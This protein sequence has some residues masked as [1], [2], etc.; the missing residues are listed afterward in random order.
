MS[1]AFIVFPTALLLFAVIT[2]A[3]TLGSGPTVIDGSVEAWFRRHA[4]PLLTD[5]MAVI[6]FLGAPTTLT[7][8]A[9]AGSVVLL[10]RERRVEAAALSMLVL[11]GDVLN[12]G[13]KHLFERGRPV[14][15]DPLFTL[16]TYSFPSGHAMASTVFYGLLAIR[17]WQSRARRP[18]AHIAIGAATSMVALVCLSRVYLGLHYPS[19]V[20][21]G[22]AEGTAWLSLALILWHR[23]RRDGGNV[24]VGR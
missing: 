7:I 21:G 16:P 13:L 19:D 11:G 24:D 20:L 15:E 18:R 5:G 23:F 10:F 14:L 12:I 22:V 17:F 3:V 8:V 1:A 6:S 2:L 9:I 4:T